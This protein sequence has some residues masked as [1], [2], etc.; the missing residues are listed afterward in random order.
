M[1][2]TRPSV[3]AIGFTVFA[4]VVL[5]LIG[6]VQFLSGLTAI[7]NDE[8]AFWVT[9]DDA[10]YWL[11]LD[12]TGWGWIHLALGVII[13]IAGLAVLSGK[14]WARTIGVAVA[15]ASTVVNFMFI[16]VYPFWSIVIIALNI[17]VIWAL[18]VHGR[19]ITKPVD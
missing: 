12:T 2:E 8:V 6:I 1:S 7:I 9:T 10:N 11:T 13:F 16:P 5:I 14:V 3:A 4:S 17:F 18:T 19:D 15:A